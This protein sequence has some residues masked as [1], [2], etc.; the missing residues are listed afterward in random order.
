MA[1]DFQKAGQ[2]LV[3]LGGIIGLLLGILWIVGA[4]FLLW[5]PFNMGFLSNIIWGIVAIVIS[6]IIL[7]TS[8]VIDIKSLKLQKNWLIL[9]ILGIILYFPAGLAG[10]IVIIGAIL[11]ALK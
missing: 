5:V 6:L 7:A 3:T 1:N 10:I 11:M 4:P 9:L 8:G 2:L